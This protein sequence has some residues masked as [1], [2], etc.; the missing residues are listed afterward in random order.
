MPRISRCPSAFTPVAVNTC[1]LT[2]RPPSRTFIVNASAARNVYGP[3]VER[4]GAEVGDL[5]VQLAGHHTTWDL[6]SRVMPSCSTSFSIRRVD[7]PSR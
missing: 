7:T 4:S 2:T 6:D 3:L 1:T 5:R